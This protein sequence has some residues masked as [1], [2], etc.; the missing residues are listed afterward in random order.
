MTGP[1]GRPGG[2]FGA[3]PE[4]A[5]PADPWA[6]AEAEHLAASGGP[7]S[8]PPASAYPVESGATVPG[9]GASTPG[10][11]QQPFL[12]VAAGGDW[13]RFAYRKPGLLLVAAGLAV[14]VALTATVLVWWSRSYPALDYRSALSDVATVT[15]P[16][17]SR[18]AVTRVVGDR[19][20]VA[21]AADDGTLLVVA[22]ASDTGAEIWRSTAA[23][24]APQWSHL[25][26]LRD[27]DTVA[28]F[29]ETDSATNARRMIILGGRA[30]ARLWERPVG[31][32]DTVHFIG[33]T[34]V[35]AERGE[36]RLLGLQLL[37]K[38]KVR[39]ERRFRQD[40]SGGTA[41]S[42]VAA[43]TADDLSGPAGADGIPFAPDLDDDQRFVLIGA[44]RSAQVFEAASGDLVTERSNVADP[45]DSGDAVLAHDGRLLVASDDDGYRVAA[46]DLAKLG[47]P[48][49]L[50]TAPDSNRRLSGLTPCGTDRV[51]FIDTAGYDAKTTEVVAVDTAKGGDLWRT[52]LA[53]AHSLVPVNGSVLVARN[54]SPAGVSLLDGAGGVVWQRTGSALRVDGGNLLYF[55]K[56]VSSYPDDVS[57][58][59]EHLGDEPHQLGPLTGTRTASCSFNDTVIACAGDKSFVLRRFAD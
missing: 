45:G 23:G 11:P 20:Y 56:P 35:V 51:C 26:G 5:P 37:G 47:E 18:F 53:D 24:A 38:G 49:G 55:A 25:V 50:Y 40:S 10:V 54:S 12:G 15:A 30:G 28:V 34:V 19:T 27:K 42:V 8:G 7:A 36:A 21:T 32:Q 14:V 41:T 13:L 57:V 3:E 2:G 46:Y 44:D 39:W 6:A 58:A 31:A 43:T 16:V 9:P 4:Y 22:V 48:T 1:D 59:G 17:S 52:Q 29:T 33:D